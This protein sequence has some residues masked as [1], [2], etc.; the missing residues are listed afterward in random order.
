MQISVTFQVP[1]GPRHT[2]LFIHH[3]LFLTILVPV[4]FLKSQ[5]IP[6]VQT[7]LEK[8]KWR[9]LEV[10]EENNTLHAEL[11]RSVVDDIA[12]YGPTNGLSGPAPIPSV[13]I[14]FSVPSAQHP[15]QPLTR[16]DHEKW[17]NELVRFFF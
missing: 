6:S 1:I 4:S 9:M 2:V 10:V 12:R 8:L 14:L 3:C 17:R 15:N 13:P 7:E 16:F 11:K 5:G